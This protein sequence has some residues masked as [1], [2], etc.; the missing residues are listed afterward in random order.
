MHLASTGLLLTLI[1]AQSALPNPVVVCLESN[2]FLGR[3]ARAAF[4]REFSM[5]MPDVSFGCA[6]E[7]VRMSIRLVPP[8]RYST[9]MG[10]A[11]TQQDRVLPL[12]EIYVEPVVRQIF[13]SR[14]P[15][16]LGRAL[17]RV[18]AHDEP[19]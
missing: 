14:S 19:E 1:C 2:G 4:D 12:L 6:P 18:A 17:A 5:V 13:G 11:F 9:A 8:S 3:H 10:L 15:V 7:A 16:I